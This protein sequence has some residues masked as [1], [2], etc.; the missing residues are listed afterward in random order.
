MFLEISSIKKHFGEGESRVEVLKGIDISI[1]KGE[2]CVLL[3]PS[4]SGKS[5]LAVAL[6]EKLGLPVVHLDQL[7][8]K[9][10]WRNVTREEFDSRLAMAM[11]MDGWIIDGNYSRTMEMRLAKCDT[12]IYLDFGRWACLRG[13][14]QRVF[15][16]YGKARPDMAQGCPERFD[17]SFVK[18]IWDYNKNNR[19]RNYMY[20]AQ[21]KHAKTI[22]LKN[23]K[24]IKAFLRN[25]GDTLPD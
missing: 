23:R 16:N 4:G 10:G 17:P 1:E 9:E 3:G 12:V 22:V 11:N 8:W 19:V 2:I 21:A 13:M 5:T 6:G 7:W 18:W 14:C 20:L 25:L 24:E 15:G